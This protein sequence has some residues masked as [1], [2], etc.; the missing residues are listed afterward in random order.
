MRRRRPDTA[1]MVALY[2]AATL[3]CASAQED[4]GTRLGVQRGGEVSFAP[5]GPG[6][7]FDALDP[8]IKKWHVPQ[9]LYNEYQWKQWEYSNYARQ[10]YQRYVD[11]NLEGDYYYDLFGSFVSRGWQIFSNSQTQPLQFGS[12]LFKSD[13]FNQWFSRLAVA[14]DQK[15]QYF[16]A[17]TIGEE[18]RSTLT[19][20]TFSKPRW[21]GVQFDVATDR[22]HGT[23]L[24]SRLSSTGRGQGGDSDLPRTNLT[25]LMGG[26]ATAQIGDFA[27]VGAH[28]VNTHQSNT[29]VD[30]FEG[31]PIAGSLTID[32]NQT[33]S[34]VEI[35]LRDDSPEDGTGGAAF[36]PAGSDIIITYLDGS[37]DR[38]KDIRFEPSI[39]GG[40]IQA[41]FRAADGT[42]EIRILYDF[43]TPAFVNRASGAK[44]E[45]ETV[46]FELTV[47][48]DYQVWMTSNRQLNRKGESV[49]LLVAQAEGNVQDNTNLRLLEFEYGL[50]TAT[51]IVGGTVEFT[52]VLGFDLYG[53]Y[54]LSLEYRRYPNVTT[55]SH[56]TSAGIRGDR[57]HEAWMLNL[58]KVDY[59][60]FFYSE[61]YSMDPLYNTRSFIT[62]AAGEID[63]EDERRHVV[64]LVDD[65]DDQDRFPDLARADNLSG[66]RKVFPG[67]DE[68]NDFIPDF[69][70][71]DNRITAN[72][73]PDYEEAFLRHNVDRPDFLFGVDM[74]NNVWIDRFENDEEPDYPYSKDHRGVNAYAGY[75]LTPHARFTLGHVREG[76]ISSTQRNHTWYGMVSLDQGV[77]R[78]GRF[79]ALQMVKLARD[80]IPD[81]LL[82]WFPDLTIRDGQQ[83]RVEDPMLAP[84]TWIT[85]TWLGNDF[86]RGLFKLSNYVKYEHYHQRDDA[87]TRSAY[88]LDRANDYF[89]GLINKASYRH[90]MG[91]AWLEPRWKSEFRRQTYG[92]LAAGKERVVTEIFGCLFG[93]PVLRRSEVQAGVEYSYFNDLLNDSNDFR[94]TVVGAQF[95]NRSPYL[96]YN[97]T[98]QVGMKVDRKDFRGQDA[99]TFTQ[100]FITMFAGL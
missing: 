97:L 29:L 16:Y 82:Q 87:A 89:F 52:D 50:P 48:N 76:L 51:Q 90:D 77:P 32:Q 47:G 38:G 86:S 10:H 71:N 1:G 94:G 35:V 79:R 81:D 88:G 96:G 26:R 37:A 78:W 65:N 67:W 57:A 100:G 73:V 20:M 33:V 23:L 25:T 85:S 44:E 59:P 21:D 13:K 31:N 68:N 28:F 99:R 3:T 43:E 42:E 36:F 55:T 75:H 80:D 11:I 2:V 61:A 93:A 84:N 58:S 19:P 7:L 40:F 17:L 64:E 14:S 74:N 45:I 92:V 56:S 49:L 9:E 18:L 41:G 8:T 69:N 15:G 24:Y 72:R 91:I 34:F 63:Y 27:A 95:V 6:V 53:E 30:G 22:Y 98:T 62:G 39:L 66:D 54:D 60:W 46:A 5:Y 83:R 12:T 4:Y 70:Q